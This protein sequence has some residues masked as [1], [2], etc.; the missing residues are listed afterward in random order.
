MCVEKD[1]CHRKRKQ[2]VNVVMNLHYS[3]K[4]QKTEFLS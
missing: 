2:A 1:E 4:Q 3:F